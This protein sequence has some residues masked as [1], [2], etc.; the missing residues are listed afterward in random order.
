MSYPRYSLEESHPSAEIQS[1]YSTAPA[2]TYIYIYIYREREREREWEG[3]RER[4]RP[5]DRQTERNGN[6]EGERDF[7]Y[8]C[9]CVIFS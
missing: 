5:I 6:K 9:H 3:E 7:Y 1:V 4:M 2:V 8:C